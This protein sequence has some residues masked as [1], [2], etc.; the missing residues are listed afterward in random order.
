VTSSAS[1][2]AIER[3]TVLLGKYRVDEII[4]RGGMGIVVKAVHLGLDEQVAIKM[5][6]EDIAIAD[7]TVARFVREAQA[8]VKLKSEHVAR[9][10]DVGTF[11][12]GTPY[13]VMEYLEGQDVGH[14]LAERGRLHASLAI[15]LVIQACEALAEAHSLGIVHRDIKPTNLFLTSRPD[16]SV[17]LKILDFGIS[18]ASS[19]PELYL[20]QTWSVLGTPAYMSP[21][22]MRSAHDVDARTDVWSLGAVLYEA[23]EGH[24]PFEAD[25]FSEMCVMV[26]VDRPAPMTATPRDLVPIISR[27][28]AKSIDERYPNVAELAR[29]LADLAS[30]PETAHVL[31][32]RMIRMLGRGPPG[33][34]ASSTPQGW[35]AT[36]PS[37]ATAP[38]ARADA[39][40]PRSLH[41][42]ERGHDSFRSSPQGAG[43]AASVIGL[44][45]GP[46]T[47]RPVRLPELPPAVAVLQHA[48]PSAGLPDYPAAA[49]GALRG[50]QPSLPGVPTYETRVP[51]PVPLHDDARFPRPGL[52][53][54]RGAPAVATTLII[55]RLRRGWLVAL[56]T[57]LIALVAVVVVIAATRTSPVAG[58]G[59]ADDSYTAPAPDQERRPPPSVK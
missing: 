30:Q 46:V 34:T 41:S 53:L 27:C 37:Q 57:A 9:I 2:T 14:L 10:S 40:P 35:A 7:E 49:G 39:T 11:D 56:I 21:E 38:V 24:L 58:P 52:Q 5:L 3:G 8:A 23:L 4:G 25:S 15:D 29:D 55:R 28:L 13:M 17:L 31:V 59:E 44:P 18:K 54:P 19:G 32:D 12:D 6:R 50:Q 33:A 26:A 36:I 43:L 48:T 47:A 45:L 22:Q 20:T 16:G 51:L 1:A 42:I